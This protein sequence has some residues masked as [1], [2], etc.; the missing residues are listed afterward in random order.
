M[1]STEF[2][3]QVSMYPLP[4]LIEILWFIS[5]LNT[6]KDWKCLHTNPYIYVGLVGAKNIYNE[7]YDN[8]S[9]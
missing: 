9:T 1:A 6:W 4:N 8:E 2:E 3:E 5:K 7:D